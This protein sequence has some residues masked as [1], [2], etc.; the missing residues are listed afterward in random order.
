VLATTSGVRVL[1]STT[2][3]LVDG[4]M[5]GL[6]AVAKSAMAWTAIPFDFDRDG[7]H[8]LYVA[9]TGQ[10]NLQPGNYQCHPAD[11]AHLQ[12]CY[13][14]PPVADQCLLDQA[15]T[16]IATWTCCAPFDLAASNLLLRNDGGNF[17][18]ISAGSNTDDAGASLASVPGDYDRDGWTDLFVGNDFGPMHWFRG[19][20]SGVFQPHAADIGL[21]P[22]GHLMGAGTGDFDGNG[23]LDLA[24]GDVG[25]VS[26]YLG[27]GGGKL[28]DM[29]TQMGTLAATA[30]MVEPHCVWCRWRRIDGNA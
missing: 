15:A 5:A 19:T 21:R 17:V 2:M 6:P 9:R 20:G 18:D 1:L 16:P 10:M 22:Y 7:D 3:G 4:G 11:G 13:G 24:T 29:A 25:P 27:Q 23:R 26:L 12:C 8:D 14:S 30:E 28:V